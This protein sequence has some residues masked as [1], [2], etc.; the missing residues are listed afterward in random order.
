MKSKVL[1]E[2]MMANKDSEI[3]TREADLV[4][5]RWNWCPHVLSDKRSSNV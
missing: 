5:T 4:S 2:N 1:D 3:E